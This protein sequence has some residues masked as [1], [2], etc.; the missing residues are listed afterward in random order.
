MNQM[1]T[2][3]KLPCFNYVSTGSC[4]Y[5]IRCAFIHDLRC[6]SDEKKF[7]KKNTKKTEIIEA[8]RDIFDYAPLSKQNYSK[9]DPLLESVTD[10]QISGYILWVSFLSNMNEIKKI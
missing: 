5:G 1:T 4:P 9:Y 2:K 6:C 7:Q 10:A 8:G 3:N